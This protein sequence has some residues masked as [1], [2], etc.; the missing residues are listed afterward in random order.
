MRADRE[1]PLA[2]G[3]AVGLDWT[4]AGSG[5]LAAVGAEVGFGAGFVAAAV[6]TAVGG[7]AVGAG[8]VEIADDR[9]LLLTDHFATEQDIDPV[10]VRL[11]LKEVDE[12]LDHFKGD[13]E[14]DEYI[15]L[16]QREAWAAVQLELHGDPPPPRMRTTSGLITHQDYAEQAHTEGQTEG[17]AAGH[18]ED[19]GRH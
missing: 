17:E 3:P 6:G 4:V 12:Q 18:L 2:T 13:P 15:M 14:S 9:A 7:T 5:G 10:R 1:E 8:F 11:E 19:G 16:V